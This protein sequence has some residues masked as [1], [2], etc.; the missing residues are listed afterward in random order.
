M[1]AAGCS[2][3]EVCA[4]FSIAHARTVPPA[5]T[6]FQISC[7]HECLLRFLI[8]CLFTSACPT[9]KSCGNDS[10]AS[11][12]PVDTLTS[13]GYAAWSTHECTQQQ[14]ARKLWHTYLRTS[15]CAS[16]DVGQQRLCQ[17]K[18]TKLSECSGARGEA[19]VHRP[20]VGE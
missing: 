9:T 2:R 17:D 1:T 14:G 18:H 8:Y 10:T 4:L 20:G 6:H 15:P 3:Y 7:I 5:P 16:S 11:G 13:S 12:L 19:S